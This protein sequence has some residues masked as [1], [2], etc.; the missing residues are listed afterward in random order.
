[1]IGGTGTRPDRKTYTPPSANG[2][3]KDLSLKA[4]VANNAPSPSTP[5]AARDIEV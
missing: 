5:N 1:M 4:S 3:G 2:I